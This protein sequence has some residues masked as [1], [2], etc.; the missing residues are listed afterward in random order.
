MKNM[1]EEIRVTVI[2]TGFGEVKEGINPK[3]TVLPKAQII[4]NL[5]LPL[6]GKREE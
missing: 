3:S 1:E 5:D 2:A 6:S 4:E